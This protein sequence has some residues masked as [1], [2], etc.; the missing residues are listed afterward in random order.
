MREASVRPDFRDGSRIK[1]EESSVKEIPL[2]M[3]GLIILKG[4]IGNMFLVYGHHTEHLYE[5]KPVTGV[6]SGVKANG[7]VQSARLNYFS[8]IAR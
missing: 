1:S 6:G 2:R 3:N 5:A 4:E 7:L 8:L